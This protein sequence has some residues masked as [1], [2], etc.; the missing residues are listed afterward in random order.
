[1]V[2]Y[3]PNEY[4]T[5]L[6]FNVCWEATVHAILNELIYYKLVEVLKYQELDG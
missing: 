6:V 2:F 1:M 4:M 5:V 3:V